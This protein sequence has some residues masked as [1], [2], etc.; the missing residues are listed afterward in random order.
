MP[1]L[2]WLTDIHLNFLEDDELDDF[3]DRLCAIDV[4][5][6]LV[7]G[8]IGEAPSVEKY[9]Q[10][11]ADVGWPVYFVLG[12]HDYYG[13]SIHEVREAVA[14]LCQREPLLHW[15]AETGAVAVS[16]GTSLIGH[17]GWGDGRLGDYK[18]SRVTLNDF[19]WIKELARLDQAARGEKLASLG[20]EA[21]ASLSTALDEALER[22]DSVLLLT[23]APPFRE[24]CWHKGKLSAPDWLPHFSCGAVGQMLRERMQEHPDHQLTVLCGHTH[25][26]GEAQILPNLRVLSGTADY[27]LPVVQRFLEV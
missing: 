20:D 6:L 24:A 3:V 14:A 5:A 12:N 17:G 23:H 19:V 10:R 11:I 1:R 4:D 8:D 25:S 18:G 15:L 27:G 7:G 13:S 22:S 2:A 9:L 26:G 16:E 21:A